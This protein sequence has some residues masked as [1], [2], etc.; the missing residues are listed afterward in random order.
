[1]GRPI[2][3]IAGCR[4]GKLVA[5]DCVSMGRAKS[6][7]WRCVCDCGKERHVSGSSI[8]RG[9]VTRCTSCSAALFDK[10]RSRLGKRTHCMSKTSEYAIWQQMM[11]RCYR[12]SVKGYMRY[13]GRGISVC[14]RWHTFTNFIADMGQRPSEKHSIDRI[15]GNGNYEPSNCRWATQKEQARNTSTNRIVTAFGQSKCIAEWAEEYS[16]GYA[17]LRN[18][19]V[20]KGWSIERAVTTPVRIHKSCEN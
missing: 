8:R 17:T 5:I 15:D 20:N 4:F 10:N 13:G 11:N 6:A 14:E 12:P 18:R 1:M 2:V 3:N 7:L 9:C 16:I 19:I